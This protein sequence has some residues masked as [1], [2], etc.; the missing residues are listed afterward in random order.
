[1][2][3]LL[4]FCPDK[5]TTTPGIITDCTNFIPYE[6]GMTAAKSATSYS[7]AL[8]ATCLGAFLG[9]K[10]DGSRRV[11]AGTSTKL[12]ELSTT[13]WTDRA[14]A[15]NYSLGATSRWS[16]CQF[17][18]TSLASNLDNVIQSSSAG[19][20]ADIATAPQAAIIEAVLSSGGGFVFAFNT[21]DGTYGTRPDGWWCSAVNDQ[22]TWTPSIAT[23]ATTGRLL[24]FEGKITAAKKLG[25]DRIVAYKAGS[26]YL[27]TYVG[28][29]QAWSWQELPGFGCVGL[30]AVANLGTAHFVVG[31]D[32]IFIFDGARPIPIADDVR[33]WFIDNSS[34]TYRY[35][36]T[37]NYDRDNNL[38][39]MYFPQ[40]ASSDG[41]P[42][43]CLVYHLLTKQWGR[44]DQSIEAAITFSAPTDTFDTG[45]GTFDADTGTFD[46][47]SAGNKTPVIF[48]TS[49]VL[50]LLSGTPTN[51]DFTTNDIG[52][53]SVV[54]HLTKATL[55]YMTT[56]SSASVDAF[57]TMAT[58][59]SQTT[60]PSQSAY[61]VPA[62]GSNQFP[63]RQTG[64]FHRLKFNFTGNVKVVGFD[65]AL[66]PAGKR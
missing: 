28:P 32:N 14:R 12:Y 31:E 7:D 60:G 44:Q 39:R 19:A 36:T 22:S 25:A 43:R 30:D 29:P 64:R 1:M 35:R 57:S 46:D 56:P 13:S 65:V 24:G 6:A 21:I 37:V 58:G 23:Q 2:T 52:D 61:D 62:N 4:G 41:T 17:G 63:L 47:V 11:F 20:F 8:A 50:C 66:K 10:L 40:S 51:S 18:D 42:D 55:R 16:F 5:Q 53:D 15:G 38:V 33:Q 3:P 9:T 48:N 45:S 26:M 59:L 49:H 34:G 54:S 27:G